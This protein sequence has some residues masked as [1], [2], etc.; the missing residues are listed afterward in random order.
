MPA[1]SPATCDIAGGPPSAS[2]I[3]RS[4]RDRPPLQYPSAAFRAKPLRSE[5]FCHAKFQ[6]VRSLHRDNNIET[7]E[8]SGL[9]ARSRGS[10][11]ASGPCDGRVDK[12]SGPIG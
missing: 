5:C 9:D 1:D 6:T 2:A 4:L 8:V 11:Y 3:A 7:V 12:A 10:D